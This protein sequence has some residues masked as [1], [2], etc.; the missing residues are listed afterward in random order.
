MINAATFLCIPYD[1]KGK[2]LIY[3]P[4]IKEVVSDIYFGNYLK[5]LTSSQEELEDE[6][7]D[8]NKD[9]VDIKKVPTPFEFLLINCY[10][11][12]QVEHLVKKAFY[13]F[14]KVEVSF[15]YEEKAILIG[16]LEEEL[17][18]ANTINDLV[19]LKEE[20]FFEFQNKIREA[21]GE[22]TVEPPNPNEHPKIRR[23][24]T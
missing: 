16:S 8:K 21:I 4:K 13:F 17:K 24:Q 5:I 23:F 14:C 7:V 12:K 11:N 18:R 1:F 6:Y 9:S 20:E 3:P 2:V 19:L 10:H 22:K 15:L